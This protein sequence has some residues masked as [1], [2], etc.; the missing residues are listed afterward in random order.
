MGRTRVV[1]ASDRPNGACGR[2]W[3]TGVVPRPWR[4]LQWFVARWCCL[5]ALL[6][7]V[8]V[9]PLPVH[10]FSDTMAQR[11]LACTGCHGED[12]RA[13]GDVFF[14]R[15]AGKPAGYLFNQLRNFRDGRRSYPL[16]GNLVSLLDDRYLQEIADY[17]AG[18]SLPY[19]QPPALALALVRQS[20][21]QASKLVHQGDP[22]RKIP[23]CTIC[24]GAALTGVQPHVPGLLGLR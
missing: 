23:A 15:I 9:A 6:S 13:L 24:H 17:F 19:S 10:A 12:G 1:R 3:R 14:P 4:S 21:D 2:Q 8:L 16:M 11:M 18:L 7:G 22:A 5:L 20:A